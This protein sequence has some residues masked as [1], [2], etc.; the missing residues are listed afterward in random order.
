MKY[1]SIRQMLFKFNFIIDRSI[2]LSFTPQTAQKIDEFGAKFRILIA[3]LHFKVDL[4]LELLHFFN[5]AK[6]TCPKSNPK[7]SG[8]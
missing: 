7:K 2:L 8:Q 6:K 4:S 3:P 1:H 5:I